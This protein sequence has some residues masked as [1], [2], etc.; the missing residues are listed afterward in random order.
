MP[1]RSLGAGS[2]VTGVAS[3][4]ASQVFTH[5][6]ADLNAYVTENLPLCDTTFTGTVSVTDGGV[7]VT[8]NPIF[9]GDIGVDGS[10]ERKW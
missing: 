6:Q 7:N 4:I 3:Q 5:Q 1:R 10:C 8:G 2:T 9:N